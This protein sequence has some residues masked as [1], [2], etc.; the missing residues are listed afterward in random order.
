MTEVRTD[1]EVK[2]G[3]VPS[4]YATMAERDLESLMGD[5]TEGLEFSFDR[6]KIPP[7][8]ATSFEIPD[9]DGADGECISV[10]EITGV[11]LYNHPAFGYYKDAYTGGNNPPDCGSFD[12]ITGVGNPG[13]SCKECPYNQFGSG[14]GQAKACKNRRMIYLLREGELFPITMSVPS[15]SLKSFTDYVKRQ[16]TKGRKLNQIVT[17]VTLKKT[18]NA[19][20]IAYS[21]LVFTFVR[22]LDDKEKSALAPMVEQ[23]KEFSKG[24]TLASIT[25]EGEGVFIDEETGEII[26]PCT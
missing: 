6:V 4:G 9:P 7:A 25:A 14:Q 21:Q 12:G 24:L 13:G 20:N 19:T 16:L 18:T 23:M 8:G 2:E 26:E 3:V 15:G 11:I 5:D 10:K 22:T 17:K 1:N